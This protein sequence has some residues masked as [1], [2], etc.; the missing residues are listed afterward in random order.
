MPRTDV[1]SNSPTVFV[2]KVQQ[3]ETHSPPKAPRWRKKEDEALPRGLVGW[4]P[5]RPAPSL[6]IFRYRQKSL[7]NRLLTEISHIQEHTYNSFPKFFHPCKLQHVFFFNR[8][9]QSGSQL[10]EE[11]QRSTK[12]ARCHRNTLAWFLRIRVLKV[13]KVKSETGGHPPLRVTQIWF[14]S[15]GIFPSYHTGV[16]TNGDSDPSLD[17]K[18][19]EH[20]GR[21]NSYLSLPSPTLS[22]FRFCPLSL[23]RND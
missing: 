6:A 10:K 14:A 8:K 16:G 4:L 22:P 12:A 19:W 7:R 11:T 2:P 21:T 1:W 17:E 3:Q 13:E 15:I 18:G 23:C 5:L 9:R 20:K